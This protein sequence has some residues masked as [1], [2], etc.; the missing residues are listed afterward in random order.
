VLK[1]AGTVLA[2]S[3]VLASVGNARAGQAGNGDV[4]EPVELTFSNP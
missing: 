4:P 3:V 2:G 1:L